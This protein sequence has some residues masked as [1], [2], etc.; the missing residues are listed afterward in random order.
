ML[1]GLVTIMRGAA[2][3]QVFD[4]RRA[5]W[6]VRHYMVEFE[7]ASLFTSAGWAFK[8]A[9]STVSGP[10]P[11]PDGCGHVTRVIARGYCIARTIGGSQ[12][13]PFECLEQQTDSLV[14]DCGRISMGQSM[15]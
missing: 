10:D 13:P 5:S 15:P 9:T 7:K 2:K 4:C 1:L 14:K 3:L 11:A 12:L 8:P 6:R